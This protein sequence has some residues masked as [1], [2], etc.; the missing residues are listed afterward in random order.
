MHLTSKV[1]SRENMEILYENFLNEPPAIVRSTNFMS[2]NE[3][4]KKN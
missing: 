1:I 3:G 2:Q 4:R